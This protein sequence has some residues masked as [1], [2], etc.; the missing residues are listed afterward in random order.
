MS[1]YT[2]LLAGGD[3]ECI[4][5][6]RSSSKSEASIDAGRSWRQ[7]HRKGQATQ[8]QATAA[9]AGV[10]ILIHVCVSFVCTYVFRTCACVFVNLR[11]CIKRMCSC[12][13]RCVSINKHGSPLPFPILHTCTG[14][15][16]YVCIIVHGL[17]VTVARHC[18]LIC[19]YESMVCL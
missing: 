6:H 3:S 2:Y 18:D 15:N 1:V 9:R 5:G 14:R 10:F 12:V 19:M 17:G 7:N 13:R 16:V 11:T 8:T 4:A